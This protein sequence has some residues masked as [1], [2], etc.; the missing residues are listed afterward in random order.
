M[1][2]NFFELDGRHKL[3]ILGAIVAWGIS[4]FFSKEGFSLDAPNS[5]WLGWVLAVIGTI[6]ELVFN[7]KANRLSL[8]LIV[9]GLLFYAY[10]VYTNI[11]G[12]WSYQNPGLEFVVTNKASILSIFVGTILEILPEP[13]FMWGMMAEFEGDIL[14]NLIG[15]WFGN[16]KYNQPKSN[17]TN[18]PPNGIP[19]N[20]T[21]STSPNIF[22]PKNPLPQP[23]NNPWPPRV[24]NNKP[25]YKPNFK[26]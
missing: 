26:K 8:T 12:F 9:V 7:S 25:Q 21:V 3:A 17:N 11:T 15:L 19:N 22:Q 23:K 4:M 24:N 13:L 20:N 10:G 1:K 14:G 18:T 16:I 5:V 6:V 2:I